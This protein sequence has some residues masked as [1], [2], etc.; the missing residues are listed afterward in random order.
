M[1]AVLLG[2]ILLL[3]AGPAL[4]RL[5]IILLIESAE[6]EHIRAMRRRRRPRPYDVGYHVG[7]FVLWVTRRR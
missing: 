4:T 2:I 3:L 7:R 5:S 6:R 1:T